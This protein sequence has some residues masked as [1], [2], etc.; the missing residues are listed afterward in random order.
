MTK[1]T[2]VKKITLRT[3]IRSVIL[4]GAGF[5]PAPTMQGF[6]IPVI[7]ALSTHIVPPSTAGTFIAGITTVDN[8]VFDYL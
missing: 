2:V 8:G 7:M 4:V 1:G 5:K 6:Y 3:V